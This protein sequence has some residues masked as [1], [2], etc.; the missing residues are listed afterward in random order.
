MPGVSWL[1]MA[2]RRAG[3]GVRG[4]EEILLNHSGVLWGRGE[5]ETLKLKQGR[6]GDESEGGAISPLSP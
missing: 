1:T 5:H 4:R 6:T 2:T 3:S